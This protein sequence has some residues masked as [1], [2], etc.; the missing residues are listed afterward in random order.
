LIDDVLDGRD[1]RLV[2]LVA[3]EPYGV[4]RVYARTPGGEPDDRLPSVNVY[5]A[6]ERR[7]LNGVGV[8]L[9]SGL[10]ATAPTALRIGYEPST[11][12]KVPVSTMTADL[13]DGDYLLRV[14]VRPGRG[15]GERLLAAVGAADLDQTIGELGP[16][17]DFAAYR[18]DEPTVVMLARHDGGPLFV[19]QFDDGAGA[20]IDR[21]EVFPIQGLR[22]PAETSWRVTNSTPL[23][24]D[25]T[26][27]SGVRATAQGEGGLDVQGD[28]SASG[29]QVVSHPVMLSSPQAVTVTLDL[30]V[31]QGHVCTGVLDDGQQNWIVPAN[32]ARERLSFVA[33]DPGRFWLVVANCSPPGGTAPSR[34]RVRDARMSTEPLTF[35]TDRLMD[36][37]FPRR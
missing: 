33:D 32:E 22:A 34:F 15:G 36:G 2:S 17:G 12:P 11:P 29:Y 24:A 27:A 13:P 23:P 7:W 10:T 19:S 21:V 25:W 8:A 6:A 9:S 16:R 30:I 26:P 14:A 4:N 1:Y 3:A 5:D 20:A 37:A 31:E 35:Y 28:G 18:E